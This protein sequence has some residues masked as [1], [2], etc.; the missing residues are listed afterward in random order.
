MEYAIIYY[1]LKTK[2][3]G[4]EKSENVL[5]EIQFKH[6]IVDSIMLKISFCASKLI[7]SGYGNITPDGLCWLRSYYHKM[8]GHDPNLQN[9]EQRKRFINYI[10]KE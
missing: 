6:N 9:K 1:G 7:T 3:E 10:E 2:K 5:K 8:Y 4:Y